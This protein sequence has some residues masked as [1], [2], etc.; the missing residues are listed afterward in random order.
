MLNVKLVSLLGSSAIFATFV[1]GFSVG[2]TTFGWLHE[3]VAK[4]VSKSHVDPLSIE[5]KRITA[6]LN[7]MSKRRRPK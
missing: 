5:I 3:P 2:M 4:I 7:K 1:I 6:N